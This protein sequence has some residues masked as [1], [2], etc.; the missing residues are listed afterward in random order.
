MFFEIQ[1]DSWKY[2]ILN[3]HSE[4]VVEQ[5]AKFYNAFGNYMVKTRSST[6]AQYQDNTNYYSTK[7]KGRQ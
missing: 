7:L 2:L 5:Y 6:G 4:T 3:R 1:L